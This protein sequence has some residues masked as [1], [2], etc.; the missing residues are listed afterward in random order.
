V[1]VAL[2]EGWRVELL[3]KAHDRKGF[4]SGVHEVNDWLRSKARQSQQKHLS[5]TKVLLDAGGKIAG[6]YTLA[7]GQVHVADLPHEIARTLPRQFL[8]V[9]TLAWM[10]RDLRYK[11]QR[12]GERL[13]ALALLDC[14]SVRGTIDFVAVVLDCLNEAAKNFYLRF[15]F[16]PFPEHPMKLLL[17]VDRLLAMYG[18]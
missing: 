2:P 13:L 3:D 11:S 1:S 16:E 6:Y 14:A 15:D 17:P 8:P 10:G 7:Y 4:D 18:Q 5:T 12:L 9:V